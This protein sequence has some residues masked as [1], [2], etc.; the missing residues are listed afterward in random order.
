MGD[1]KQEM[2]GKKRLKAEGK[3]QSKVQSRGTRAKLRAGKHSTF[4]VLC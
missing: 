2:G 3:G 4:N 1:W